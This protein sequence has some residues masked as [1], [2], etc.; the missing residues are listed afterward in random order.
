[1]TLWIGAAVL[2]AAA[3]GFVLV[4]AWRH[5]RGTQ[6]RPVASLVAA[7][8]LVPFAIGLYL[9][10]TTWSESPPPDAALPPVNDMVAGL[11]ERLERNPD[12]VAG[13]RLL[14]Q[15]YIA[16]GR[17]AQARRALQEAWD[18]TDMPDDALRVAFAEAS[19]LEDRSSLAGE[20]GALFDEVLAHDPSNQKALWYGGLAA[21]MKQ[22]P[23]LARERWSRLLALGPPEAIAQ[24]LREQIEVLGGP[25]EASSTSAPSAGSE[26][27]SPAQPAGVRLL[28]RV[29]EALAAE[30]PDTASLFIFA[31]SPGG[32]PPVAV[33][34]RSAGALPGEF[35]LSDADAMIPGRSLADFDTLTIVARISL[36]GQPTEQP[37][38]LFGRISYRPG[39]DLDVQE[40]VIDQT[41]R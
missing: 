18:R 21:L 12:D 26:A 30:V 10:V 32:G 41:V 7:G 11:A 37:G 24:V 17:Y 6:T 5:A 34:R 39:D 19:A 3:L 16:L 40:L 14:G 36:S 38:D 13:W 1:M 27:A 25:L 33:L 28:I 20:A 9:Q 23:E 2:L 4:P 29:D 8:L 31:R 35:G 15:S 22:Q